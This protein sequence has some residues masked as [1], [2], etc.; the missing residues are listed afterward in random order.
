MTIKCMHSQPKHH[1]QRVLI[2]GISI[3]CR[4][5]FNVMTQGSI[6]A[7]SI[8]NDTILI[9]SLANEVEGLFIKC[10]EET[11]LGEITNTVSSLDLY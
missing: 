4:K 5:V 2:N 1:I 10:A 11:K 8:F 6:L 3:N 7:P 9:N